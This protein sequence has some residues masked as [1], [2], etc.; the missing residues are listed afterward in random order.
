MENKNVEEDQIF[1][2]QKT[3]SNKGNARYNRLKNG[4][5]ENFGFRTKNI[6]LSLPKLNKGGTRINKSFLK[7]LNLTI[8]NKRNNTIDSLSPDK[9]H[10]FDNTAQT[11]PKNNKNNFLNIS[12]TNKDKEFYYP[13]TNKFTLMFQ[14]SKSNEIHQKQN[15]KTNYNKT[16]KNYIKKKLEYSQNKEPYINKSTDSKRFKMQ[17]I[18]SFMKKPSVD[19]ITPI[20]KN[21]NTYIIREEPNLKLLNVGDLMNFKIKKKYMSNEFGSKLEGVNLNTYFKLGSKFS[22]REK[23]KDLEKRNE[24]YKNIQLLKENKKIKEKKKIVPMRNFRDI[25]EYYKNNRFD[26]CRKLIEQT[27]IDVKK[28]KNIIA[29]FFE[30]YKKVF[31]KFDDWNDPKNKDNLYSY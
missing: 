2:Y 13:Q 7:T 27:L 9:I 23:I 15:I 20:D 18:Y 1:K 26:N 17:N 22:S 25:L 10:K 14:K 28:E 24:F 11:S 3:E 5:E 4:L 29:E 6:I 30:N 19:Y 8:K 12:I 21:V 31:D 16:Y